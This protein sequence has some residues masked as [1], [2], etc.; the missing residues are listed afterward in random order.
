METPEILNGLITVKQTERLISLK[1]DVRPKRPCDTRVGFGGTGCP[2]NS[3]T[4]RD[5]NQERVNGPLGHVSR[6]PRMTLKS[7]PFFFTSNNITRRITRVEFP[8]VFYTKDYNKV[9]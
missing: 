5:A 1:I 2:T 3:K 4:S 6:D 9:W 7:Q 8:T